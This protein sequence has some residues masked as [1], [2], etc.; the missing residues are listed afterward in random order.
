MDENQK[1]R[2]M[3]VARLAGDIAFL[4]TEGPTAKKVEAAIAAAL[5]NLEAN[6][7]IKVTPEEE[8]PLF[9]S[10]DSPSDREVN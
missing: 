5:T 10:L 2:L 1:L 3:Q 8:W 7:L 9:V 4:N 6:G